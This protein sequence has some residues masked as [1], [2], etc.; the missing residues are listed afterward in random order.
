[1]KQVEEQILGILKKSPFSLTIDE[2]SKKI[3]LTR[4]TTSKYLL[5]LEGK[6]RVKRR[7]VGTAKLYYMGERKI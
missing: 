5:Y 3:G 6:G 4:Q 1:M 7:D 2:V